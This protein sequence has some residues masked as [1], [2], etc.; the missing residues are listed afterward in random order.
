MSNVAAN[1]CRVVTTCAQGCNDGD[2][3][4]RAA[5]STSRGE[6]HSAVFGKAGVTGEEV[7]TG[8]EKSTGQADQADPH[9]HG[10]PFSLVNGPH[11]THPPVTRQED[12]AQSQSVP[13]TKL[14]DE[15]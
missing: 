7:V 8:G 2:K 9:S 10:A 6:G 1:L 5:T 3:C 11:P 13:R 4:R 14:R 12:P 15:V